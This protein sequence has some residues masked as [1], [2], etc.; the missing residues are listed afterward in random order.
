MEKTNKKDFVEL[1]YT[2]YSNG[3]AFDSNVEEELKKIDPEAKIRETVV[4][5][6][7]GMVVSGFDKELEGK[8]TEK[9]YEINL[10]AKDA[11]GER[12][13]ELIK[14]IPLKIFTEKEISPKAGMVFVMDNTL[15]KVIAVSGARVITD[16]NN[17]LAG[18]DVSYKFK[19][20]RIVKDD[21]E[22]AKALFEFVFKFVPEFELMGGEIVIKGPKILESYAKAFEKKFKE[23]LGKALKFVLKEEKTEN[24]AEEG[25]EQKEQAN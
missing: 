21:K 13:R 12:R 3:K 7:E 4:C 20:V 17:P 9:D 19:V 16:F 6:G 25:K 2:G 24:K 1:K 15:A 8:E 22:K 10:C 14:T 18:K 23:L 5:I 11:F